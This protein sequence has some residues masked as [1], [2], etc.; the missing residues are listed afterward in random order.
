M[1]FRGGTIRMGKL[2]MPDADMQ[3]VDTDESDPFDFYIDRYNEQLVAGYSRNQQN[4]G[5]LVFMR[6]FED[7]GSPARAGEKLPPP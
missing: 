4:Y 5:L 2:L 1:Y 3:V 7:I 6:D